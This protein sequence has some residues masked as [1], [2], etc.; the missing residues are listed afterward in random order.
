MLALIAGTNDCRVYPFH[1][2][3]QALERCGKNFP[4]QALKR[5]GGTG[6]AQGCNIAGPCRVCGGT[7]FRKWYSEIIQWR[8][9]VLVTEMH[10]LMPHLMTN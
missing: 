6:N 5:P 7:A 3:L 1:P 2:G 8:K 10:C 9:I 4:A